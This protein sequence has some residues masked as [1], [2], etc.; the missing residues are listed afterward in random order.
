MISSRSLSNSVTVRA[1]I[2]RVAHCYVTRAVRRIN[3]CNCNNRVRP[4]LIICR[5]N[6]L[7]R[8]R[9]LYSLQLRPL[10]NGGATDRNRRNYGSARSNASGNVLV[11]DDAT[12]RLL[13][14]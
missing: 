5:I 10:L 8:K 11:N 3:A 2:R 1:M 9:L 12:R 6:G 4:D 7:I 14:V 13:G